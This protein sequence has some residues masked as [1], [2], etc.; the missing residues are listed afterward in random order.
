MQVRSYTKCVPRASISESRPEKRSLPDTATSY[1]ADT[2][3]DRCTYKG[4]SFWGR[5]ANTTFVIR[6]FEAALRLTR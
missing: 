3:G 2:R 4:L 1:G 5:H 6:S